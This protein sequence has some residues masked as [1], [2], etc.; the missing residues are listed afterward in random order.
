M[1]RI[2]RISVATTQIAMIPGSFIAAPLL[3]VPGAV[4][5]HQAPQF[6]R[7][8]FAFGVEVGFESG[9]SGFQSFAAA[10]VQHV[11]HLIGLL[12]GFLRHAI[13][14]YFFLRFPINSTTPV[15]RVVSAAPTSAERSTPK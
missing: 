9:E 7:R 13:T 6:R 8:D 4:K 12:L 15:A 10:P 11:G 5:F 1:W 3:G 14:A 2:T